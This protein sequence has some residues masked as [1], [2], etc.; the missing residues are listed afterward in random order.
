MTT[1][2]PMERM[3]L[4]RRRKAFASTR[5]LTGRGITDF[6]DLVASGRLFTETPM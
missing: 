1:E 6:A 3:G 5:A 2:L 4:G